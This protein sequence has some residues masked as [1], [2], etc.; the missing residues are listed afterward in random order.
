MNEIENS[1]QLEGKILL[2]E[3]N[4]DMQTMLK[5]LLEDEGFIVKISRTAEEGL[6]IL[7]QENF[8]LVLA[9]IKLP[10]KSGLDILPD[11]FELSPNISVIYITAY[12]TIEKAVQAVKNGAFD[13]ITKPFDPDYLI[14]QIKRAISQNVLIR[15]YQL[16][17]EEFP[18]LLGVP[19]I[20]GKSKVFMKV[21][22]EVKKVANSDATVLILGESGTGKEL[23][24]RA[25]H[26][27]SPRAKNP[28]IAINCAAIPETLLENELFGHEKGAYTGAIS[29]QLG[30]F[31]LANKGSILL[32]EIGELP[33][34][35]QVKLLRV[36]EEK[37]IERIGGSRS[38]KVDVRI[39]ASTNRD[40]F[41]M[42]KQ[43]KFRED[44]YYRLNVFPI[45]LP[46]LRQ[47]KEDILL[48]A[49]YFLNKFSLDFKKQ[50]LYLSEQAKEK[51]LNY[52]WP[53]NVRELQ[54]CIERA[55]ILAPGQIIEPQ[56][57]NISTEST[58]NVINFDDFP[59]NITLSEANN[60]VKS[61]LEKFLIK[62][63]L[64][65]TKGNKQQAASLLDINYRYL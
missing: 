64:K 42:V 6:R 51:L 27:L 54:N 52:H 12:G 48:L 17:K 53:G 43:K 32:D 63:A 61:R 50:K 36:I 15:K 2:I 65:I 20:I 25:V 30:K 21:L 39:I 4:K 7:S 24:A 41:Q 5:L 59:P 1:S 45:K 60:Y 37:T 11:I 3:D 28:F 23:I 10:G 34:S 56:H 31:E 40:L 49:E 38:I 44:L 55:V 58:P 22:E 29:R 47:R 35:L 33:L 57:I 19:K 14:L 46:P 26:F 8:D 16:F 62:R 13:F 9:D 18:D